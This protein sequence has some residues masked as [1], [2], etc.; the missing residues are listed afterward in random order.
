MKNAMKQL[1]TGLAHSIELKVQAFRHLYVL[2]TEARWVQTVDVDSGLP[3]YCPLEVTVR[4]TEHYA[5]TSFYEVTPCILPERAVLKAVRVCGP[6]YWSQ[7]INHIP[8]E[9]PWSSGDK[10]DAL[11]SGILYV[12]RKVGACSYVDD[13][14]G[15]Q[16]LL[17]RAMH[18]VFGLTRL[19][20]SA[21]S[22]DCQDSDMVDQ[23]IS[24]F[25][26]NPSLISFAQLCCDPNWN[27][28]QVPLYSLLI[29]VNTLAII[30]LT[31][32]DIDFQEFC[33]QVLFE[34]VSKD[35][36][37][38]LQVYLS[39]YT[40]IGSMVDRITSSS[41]NLQDTLF[42][43]SLKIA[44]AYNNGLLS[45]KSTS[46][47]EGIVQSTFLGSVQK[48][49]EEILSSSLEFQKDF[50]TYTKSGRWPTEDDGRRASTFLSW[51]VQWYNVPSPFEVKRALDKIKA[52]NAS[53]S[54]PLLHLVFPTTD[55][56][57]LCEINR[58]GFC[59]QG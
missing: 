11:S 49:V 57:A 56:T 7:V 12:K 33:L 36:P 26:S 9:K 46:S 55:V 8:E 16:S 47:K 22:R 38:L 21:A 45:K 58:V 31:Q 15:C 6:R 5:E 1:D 17:S 50:S 32:S 53:S 54:V 44:L 4:E 39:L 34:C 23:L 24:T 41:S 18:K 59:S 27:S 10:S 35:R 25:S 40:T 28:R 20:A 19:R 2:A 14:A 30:F 43:S 3:V 51:Y 42:I 52:I 48:R 13:P 37:A 29:Q